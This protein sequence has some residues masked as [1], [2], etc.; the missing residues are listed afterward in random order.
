MQTAG[1]ARR[2]FR[3][4]Y[5]PISTDTGR[6]R[7]AGMLARQSIQ[8]ILRLQDLLVDLTDLAYPSDPFAVGQVEDL[9]QAPV[10]M[11]GDKRHFLPHL[12]MWVGHSHPEGP[13]PGSGMASAP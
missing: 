2:S 7:P 1:G 12:V 8:S 3:A 4:R 6:V 11:I 13:S 10:E 5:W 9:L